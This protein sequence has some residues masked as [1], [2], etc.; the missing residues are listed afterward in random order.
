[1]EIKIEEKFETLKI[2][3]ICKKELKKAYMLAIVIIIL[4]YG[5]FIY[6]NP[7]DYPMLIIFLSPPSWIIFVLI[8][9]PYKYEVIYIHN[10]KIRFS[11]SYTEENAE[12]AMTSF[13][14]IKN[15]KEF[16]IREYYES[17]LRNI[18]KF[19]NT[20]NIPHYKIHF[21]FLG[22][23]GYACWGYEIPIIEAEKVVRRINNFLE[24][25]KIYGKGIYEN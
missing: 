2:S 6:K 8:C 15:L 11:S 21:I 25:Q 23:E 4:L 12:T 17:S 22:E 14:L 19:E 10:E 24:K 3:K 9:R 16:Y 7:K 1:M 13:F 20:K 5:Y 18:F